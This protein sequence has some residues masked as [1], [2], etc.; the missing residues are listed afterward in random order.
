MSRTQARPASDAGSNA[1]ASVA[2]SRRRLLGMVRAASEELDDV[3][4][5][6]SLASLSSKLHNTVP[7]L[8]RVVGALQAAGY[9]VSGTHAGA[10]LIKTDAPPA[11]MWSMLLAAAAVPGV[12]SMPSQRYLADPAHVAHALVASHAAAQ[13]VDAGMAALAAGWD[14]TPQKQ[15]SASARAAKGPR[16]LPAPTAGWGPQARASAA[17]AA[18][19]AAV[20][21][22]GEA[23]A[24][25]GGSAASATQ[26]KQLSA[27]YKPGWRGKGKVK[28]AVSA[29]A[30]A[31]P[32]SSSS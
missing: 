17:K 21:G 6:Y 7:P 32:S 14:F 8:G 9:R 31:A 20:R 23:A 30:S 19:L 13:A 2:A 10:N 18:H 24:G 28:A 1:A 4:L 25:E 16:H 15:L 29:P 3:P 22:E 11:A 27:Q 12:S 5:Y 26:Q